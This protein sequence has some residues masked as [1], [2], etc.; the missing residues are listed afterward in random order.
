MQEISFAKLNK[1]I[2]LKNKTQLSE[3]RHPIPVM[4]YFDESA[5]CES[6]FS[7]NENIPAKNNTEL[8]T[9]EIGPVKY[10]DEKIKIKFVYLLP[11]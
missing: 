9:L 1:Q 11:E 4:V 6:V 2:R 10:K 3:I 7:M 8:T 5:K